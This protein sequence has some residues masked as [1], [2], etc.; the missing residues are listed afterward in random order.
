[1]SEEDGKNRKKKKLCGT[2]KSDERNEFCSILNG[3]Q[4]KTRNKTK[5]NK[6]NVA[7]EMNEKSKQKILTRKNESN[8]SLSTIFFF[9]SFVRLF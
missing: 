3:I 7:N 5:Q 8:Y 1:M 4:K 6:K 9:F 2:E